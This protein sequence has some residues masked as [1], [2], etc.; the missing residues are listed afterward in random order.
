MKREDTEGMFL[1]QTQ[2]LERTYALS[3]RTISFV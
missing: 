2:E 1:A 3:N